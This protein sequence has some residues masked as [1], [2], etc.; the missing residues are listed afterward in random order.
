MVNVL[1]GINGV[2]ALRQKE[3]RDMIEWMNNSHQKPS[4]KCPDPYLASPSELL[5]R[6]QDRQIM[7]THGLDPIVMSAGEAKDVERLF[8]LRNMLVHFLPS[9]WSIELV[10]LPRIFFN[11]I[12]ITERMIEHPASYQL[13]PSERKRIRILMLAIGRRLV[14]LEKRL[15]SGRAKRS[16]IRRR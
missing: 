5:R 2:D 13:E 8:T 14:I 1:G 9:G 15:N 11:A 10:G 12:R 3:R 4:I 7:R 16:G 6:V